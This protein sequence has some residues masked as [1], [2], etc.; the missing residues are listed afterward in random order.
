MSSRPDHWSLLRFL[1]NASIYLWKYASFRTLKTSF[2]RELIT[3]RPIHSGWKDS[4]SKAFP[5]RSSGKDHWLSFCIRVLWMRRSSGR[6]EVWSF[7]RWCQSTIS[8]KRSRWNPCAN[9]SSI[10]L[11]SAL[12][13]YRRGFIDVFLSSNF[14]LHWVVNNI[15]KWLSKKRVFFFTLNLVPGTVRYISN[16]S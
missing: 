3:I 4:F 5:W 10:F 9:I 2:L 16:Y 13:E 8:Q 7:T 15:T 14:A 1:M 12:S 6:Q 11:P